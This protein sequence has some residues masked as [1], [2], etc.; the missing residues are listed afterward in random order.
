MES[1]QVDSLIL[2]ADDRGFFTANGLNVT[3]R[4]YPSGAAAVDGMMNGESDIATLQ[5]SSL[6]EKPLNMRLSGHLPLSTASS[7]SILSGGVIAA[8]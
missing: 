7:R 5:S 2:I 1:N 4:N 3:I 6:S 8:S